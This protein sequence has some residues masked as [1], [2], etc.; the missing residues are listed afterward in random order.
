MVEKRTEE[1]K[2]LRTEI[3]VTLGGKEY[4]IAPLVIKYSGE[5]RKKA[6]PLYSSLI[7]YSHLS[8]GESSGKTEELEQAVVELFTTRTDEMLDSFFEYARELPREEIENTATDGEVILAFMEVFN[9]FVAPFAARA[10]TVKMN[11]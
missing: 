7:R 1:D 11:T 5:W 3:K 4:T 2:V 6:L 8:T 10:E 9:A